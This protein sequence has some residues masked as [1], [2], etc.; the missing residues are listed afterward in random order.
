MRPDSR[1]GEPSCVIDVHR[2]LALANSIHDEIIDHELVGS[3]MA[4]REPFEF[5]GQLTPVVNTSETSVP[6]ALRYKAWLQ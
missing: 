4:V 1:C 2:R 5:L 6:T 3:A